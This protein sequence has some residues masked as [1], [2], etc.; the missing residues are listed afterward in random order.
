M[1]LVAIVE[2]FNV[3]KDFRAC[4]ISHLLIAVM[5]EFVLQR[6]EETF[7]HRV[8]VAVALAAH[9]AQHPLLF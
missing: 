2:Q 5:N 6:T 9:A 7:S 4:L 3:I 1:K 8:V